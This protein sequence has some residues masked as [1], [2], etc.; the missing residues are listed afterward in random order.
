MGTYPI[1]A[2][3]LV[4]QDPQAQNTIQP[5]HPAVTGANQAQ[6][7]PQDTVAISPAARAQQAA[8]TAEPRAVAHPTPPNAAP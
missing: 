1:Q 7:A 2:N 3:S 6:A 5:N 8:V 4:S